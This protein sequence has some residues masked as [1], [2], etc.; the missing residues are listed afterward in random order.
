Q[1]APELAVTEGECRAFYDTNPQQFSQ[2]QRYRASHLF[3]AAPQGTAVE[4][5]QEKRT[6]AQALVMRI[7]GGESFPALAGETSED[8]ATKARAGDLNYFSSSRIPPEF[9]TEIEKLRRGQMS[10]PLQSHLGF[11]IVQ[12]T[13][14]KPPRRLAFEEAKSEIAQTLANEKR[15]GAVAQ[16]GE[17]LQD[18]NFLEAA[19]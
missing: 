14:S 5:V 3:I 13:G 8:E 4:I 9:F 16:L 18:S 7:L 17:R 2:P 1:I 15:A 19:R 11:H 6:F 10:A 12:L